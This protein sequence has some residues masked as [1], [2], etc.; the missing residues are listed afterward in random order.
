MARL[1]LK[2]RPGGA[3]SSTPHLPVSLR[4]ISQRRPTGRRGVQT[5]RSYHPPA[6]AGM[7]SW[8]QAARPGS[9]HAAIADHLVSSPASLSAPTS[10][11]PGFLWAEAKSP[12]SPSAPSPQTSI[13]LTG[14]RFLNEVGG[15]KESHPPSACRVPSSYSCCDC[16]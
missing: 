9:V 16:I 2:P 12:F 15:D 1:G 4:S 10:S 14:I 5:S 3:K 7:V 6:R 13:H 8:S 11:A